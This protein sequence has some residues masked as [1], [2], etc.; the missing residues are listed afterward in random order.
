[1]T[2]IRR[3]GLAATALM[4]FTALAVVRW[5]ETAQEG[6]TPEQWRKN[7]EER[8]ATYERQAA[9]IENEWR[10]MTTVIDA[11]LG[12][13]ERKISELDVLAKRDI[14]VYLVP[15]LEFLREQAERLCEEV[16]Q[17]ERESDA[18]AA[19][20]VESAGS[21]IAAMEAATAAAANC[22]D[23]ADA[24]AVEGRLRDAVQAAALVE[25]DL[26]QLRRF[27]DLTGHFLRL[28]L[29][30][31]AEQ[32]EV[33]RTEVHS[34]VARVSAAHSELL[35]LIDDIREGLPGRT[36]LK[37]RLERLRGNV[38]EAAEYYVKQFPDSADRWDALQRRLDP[39]RFPDDTAAMMQRVR[40]I[41]VN[42][43]QYATWLGAAN[44][45]GY[46][47]SIPFPSC[48]SS[49]RLAALLARVE[50]EAHFARLHLSTREQL[51]ERAR[52]CRQGQAEAPTPS[53]DQPPD[54]PVPP[55]VLTGGIFIQGP[56]RLA[57]G[58]AAVYRAVDGSGNPYTSGV[59]WNALGGDIVILSAGGQ[60]RAHRTG[61]AVVMAFHPDLGRTAFLDVTVE[62][63][64]DRP[65]EQVAVDPQ[66]TGDGRTAAGPAFDDGFDRGEDDRT[67]ID[68]PSEADIR[69]AGDPRPPVDP[70]VGADPQ[71]PS[72][73]EV[74]GEGTGQ[75]IE[76]L[77]ESLP[78]Q[79]A[80]EWPS[81]DAEA[82][83]DEQEPTGFEVLGAET[84]RVEES[85]PFDDSSIRLL[86]HVFPAPAL[87]S[88]A[89]TSEA[90]L[91]EQH[92]R[93]I[94]AQRAEGARIDELRRSQ[95]DER[96]QAAV[97]MFGLIAGMGRTVQ[98]LSQQPQ[99]QPPPVRTSGVAGT[100][101]AAAP[102]LSREECEAKFCPVCTTGG[103][104]DLL[105]VSVN[106]Q[107]TECRARFKTQIEDCM[108]G[109]ASAQRR[110]ASM[111]G[112][113]NYRVL[114]CTVRTPIR[115]REGRIVEYR[116]YTFFDVA[117]PNRQAPRNAACTTMETCTWE[118][119]IRLAEQSNSNAG[120]GHQVLH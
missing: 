91:L 111:S 80:E 46:P 52:A 98:D 116:E 70:L 90:Q 16:R 40:H 100:G 55:L 101:T 87:S 103:S 114:R 118:E 58:Q 15:R 66:D 109:G 69:A 107:C 102:G 76:F 21:C 7:M 68:A 8:L 120:T 54:S 74:P 9:A 43:G 23:A 89:V 75:T 50:G 106:P 37:K 95:E 17:I 3:S 78:S 59:E 83:T 62:E 6:P 4:L 47:T 88:S 61:N 39:D 57:P 35:R 31:L 92:Q 94:E 64:A 30:P 41:Q 86:D 27:R 110:D 1:M 20:A 33:L 115:D 13:A 119:C 104:V 53:P 112:F 24:E 99:P 11:V 2:S 97:N 105:G 28:Y 48:D 38:A 65:P 32:Y 5:T 63:A 10:S 96:Q 117:G 85:S 56:T 79:A 29:T 81:F 67:G 93:W 49:A 113:R 82:S 34:G 45:P 108:R 71:A 14:D 26:A 36:E 19:R 77:G 42:Q 12:P 25:L 51:L 60:A 84:W 18:Y 44:D 22:A 72:G 73:F